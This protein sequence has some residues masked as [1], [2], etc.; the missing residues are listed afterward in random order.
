MYYSKMWIPSLVHF[1]PSPPDKEVSPFWANRGAWHLPFE[2]GLQQGDKDDPQWQALS[3]ASQACTWLVCTILGGL[4]LLREYSGASKSNWDQHT[5]QLPCEF[6]R[7]RKRN[8]L[9]HLWA[10]AN[11]IKWCF[12]PKGIFNWESIGNIQHALQ[13]LVMLIN[14]V[15][16]EE[17]ASP[18]RFWNQIWGTPISTNVFIKW[19]KRR[20][21]G[22]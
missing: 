19:K 16:W 15:K 17:T 10:Y 14:V 9:N 22:R 6:S 13:W 20:K 18:L 4:A 3:C 2:K 12:V 11:F 7:T 1:C 5:K 21:L 8:F